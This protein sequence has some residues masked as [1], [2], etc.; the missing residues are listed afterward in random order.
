MKM[1]SPPVGRR[2]MIQ[3]AQAKMLRM[4]RPHKEPDVKEPDFDVDDKKTGS[5]SSAGASVGG[6]T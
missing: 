3:R 1:R 4:K 2:Q 6:G 5:I